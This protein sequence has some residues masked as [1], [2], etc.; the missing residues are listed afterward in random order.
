MARPLSTHSDPRN[1]F[2]HAALEQ[3]NRSGIPYVVGGA[4]ALEHY[5][6]ISRRTK[7]LDVFTTREGCGRVLRLFDAAGYATELTSSHWLGKVFD[8]D[9][10]MDVIFSSGNGLCEVDE[11]WFAHAVAG[12]LL[13]VPVRFSPAEEMIWS[14]AFIMERERFDG[15]DV[16]HL[17]RACALNWPRLIARFGPHGHVL[18][19]HLI[20]FRFIY[21][22]QRDRV[23]ATVLR[24]LLR[25]LDREVGGPAAASP[26]CHGTLLS[27]QQYLSDLRR[28]Y[29]D[30]RLAPHGTMTA[31]EVDRWT[32]AFIDR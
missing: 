5:T 9:A 25:R 14:K 3:L 12:E 13:G 7:D 17:I 32:G 27:L 22:D 28:G 6:G 31:E 24:L 1:A 2:Y 10:F 29:R 20:L 30:A 16:A 26:V 4:Y 15:A 19:S 21:P 18:L 8:G 11:A 23:P